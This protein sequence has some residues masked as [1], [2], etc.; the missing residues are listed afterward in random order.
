MSIALENPRT[1]PALV[2]LVSF[3]AL[4]AAYAAQYWGGLEPCALCLYQRYVYMA[5]LAV[6]LAGLLLAGSPRLGQGV[7]LA[8]GLVFLAGLAISAFHVGVEQ[9]WWRGTAG[10]HAPALDLNASVAELREQMLGKSFTPCDEIP[11]SLFGISMAGYN[12]LASLALA[13]ASFWAAR[14]LGRE[15]RA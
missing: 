9:H 1:P 2:A 4:A 10:C 14:R 3:G 7:L 15:G 6:G 13:G 8:A 11:W 12:A 5:A